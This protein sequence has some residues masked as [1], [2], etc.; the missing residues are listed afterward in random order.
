MVWKTLDDQLGPA[1][2]QFEKWGVAGLKVDFMQR[3]DQKVM[4]YYHRVSR[5]CA[6]RKMLVDFHG[7][8]RPAHMTR[9]WPN[10]ITTE[11]VRASSTTSGPT[12]DPEHN[13]TLPFTRMF[14][15]PLD[16]T[17]GAMR[18]ASKKSFAPIFDQ[19]MSLGT[20]CHQLAMYVVYESPLQMLADSPRP[21]CA[22]PRSWSSWGR[23][24]PLGRDEGCSTPGSG[25]TWWSRGATDATGTS[26]P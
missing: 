23:C 10:L 1:M 17:P 26:A 25:T 3:D 16:Y 13:V 19:P 2:D 20:R 22:S 18:N 11:G 7:A 14:V 4:D 8:I 24:R 6:K 21:T 5:E 15:G 12:S 9:T